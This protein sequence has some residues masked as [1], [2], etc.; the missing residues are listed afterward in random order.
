MTA[1]L[2]SS[3]MSF[4]HSLIPSFVHSCAHSFVHSFIRSFAHSFIR[5]FVH[6]ISI[7]KPT[8]VREE[9]CLLD[10]DEDGALTLLSDEDG[11]TREDVDLPAGGDAGEDSIA[12]KIKAAFED[13]E[14]S[15][16]V[17][18]TEAKGD[19]KDDDTS[20]TVT[21]FKLREE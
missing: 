10:I 12:S 20:L 4:L 18:V 19:K 11:E 16:Y 15:V 1:I 17:T 9:Y 14:M 2:S 5:S 21:D 7:D 8:V 3:Y 13:S 6:S